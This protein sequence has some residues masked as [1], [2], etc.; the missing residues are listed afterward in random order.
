M[1]TIEKLKDLRSKFERSNYA[2]RI[3]DD[4]IYDEY[5][6]DEAL[7]KILFNSEAID[8]RNILWDMDGMVNEFRKVETSLDPPEEDD[9]EEEK[10]PRTPSQITLCRLACAAIIEI[11]LNSVGSYLGEVL[12]DTGWSDVYI[13]DCLTDNGY[14]VDNEEII[15]AID[16]II[17]TI[18]EQ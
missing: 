8:G 14:Y 10:D 9:D 11:Y 1:T 12:G 2:V 15:A 16:D 7:C 18:D 5:F 13:L 17:A 4:L 6:D 3:M